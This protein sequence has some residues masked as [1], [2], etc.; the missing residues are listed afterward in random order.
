MSPL[1]TSFVSGVI[2]IVRGPALRYVRRHWYAFRT[3]V[4]S[5]KTWRPGVRLAPI[6]DRACVLQG[7]RESAIF[8]PIRE[9]H[10]E[11]RGPVSIRL[12]RSK[13]A[14]ARAPQPVG[15]HCVDEPRDFA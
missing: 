5:P 9:I 7:R 11:H 14:T 4:S 12:K 10:P 13:L 1:R 2:D 15:C 6:D 8:G 3:P